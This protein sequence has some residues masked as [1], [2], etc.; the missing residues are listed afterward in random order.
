LVS[1]EN[2][3]D[4]ALRAILAAV[5]LLL[6]SP[7]RW[8]TPSGYDALGPAIIDAVWSI[9]VR[10]QSVENVMAR[11]RAVRLAGG[12]DPEADRPGDVRRFIEACGGAEEFAQRMGNRQ[13]TSTTNGILKA[14]AVLHEARV[15]EDEGVELPADLTRASQ[16]RLDHLQRRWSTVPGQGSGVSWRAFSMLVGLPEV[17][18][19]RMIRRFAA[20]ALGR[21]RETAVGVDEARDLVLGAAARLGVSPR[22]LDNAIWSYQSRPKVD[23]NRH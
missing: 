10:Y 15:L 4:D 9:G 19:D 16:E 2:P 7:D 17:K 18:P 8:E 12:G 13:R 1:S 5:E 14:E 21:P 6:P 22:A 20:A 11:Y 23:R 3:H